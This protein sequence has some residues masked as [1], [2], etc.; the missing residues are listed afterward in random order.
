MPDFLIVG[1]EKRSGKPYPRF[2]VSGDD[3]TAARRISQRQ[4]LNIE[5]VTLYQRQPGETKPPVR[6]F[7]PPIPDPSVHNEEVNPGQPTSRGFRAA[8]RRIF[9]AF[10]IAGVCIAFVVAL[11]ILAGCTHVET[12]GETTIY[13]YTFAGW[14]QIIGVAVCVSVGLALVGYSSNILVKDLRKLGECLRGRIDQNWPSHPFAS[15]SDPNKRGLGTFLNKGTIVG[16]AFLILPLSCDYNKRE[17]V[18]V[19]DDH[20]EITSSSNTKSI[21]FSTLSNITIE[22]KTEQTGLGSHP[23]HRYVFNMKGGGR[24]VVEG[25]LIERARPQIVANAQK[26]GVEL[27]GFE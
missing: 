13:T 16:L 9:L 21:Y 24:E 19:D 26:K 18:V 23:A 11:L 4:W 2:I 7:G 8:H 20:L 27:I 14:F 10:L 25:R 12:N 22:T 5:A 6:P 15:V 17:S 1:S 3:E